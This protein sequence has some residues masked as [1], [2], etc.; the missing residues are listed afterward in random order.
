MKMNKKV[1][2]LILVLLLAFTL[3]SCGNSSGEAPADE[4][5]VNPVNLTMELF[6]GLEDAENDGFESIPPSSFIAEEGSTVLEATELFCVSNDI[7]ITID[8]DKSYVTEIGGLTEKDYAE[9][10]GWIFKVNGEI[11]SVPADQVIIA[12]NDEI[13]WEFVDFATYSW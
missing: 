1:L 10:T 9:T 7:S 4:P 11:P 2:N 8:T 12:E 5:V 6:I 3:V 13:R